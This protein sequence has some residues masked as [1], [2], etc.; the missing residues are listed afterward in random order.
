MPSGDETAAVVHCEWTLPVTTAQM[1]QFVAI[2]V[3]STKVYPFEVNATCVYD[4]HIY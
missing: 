3:K 1:A 2:K 4:S